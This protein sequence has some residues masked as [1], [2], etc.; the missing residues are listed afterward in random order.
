MK[1]IQNGM[2]GT[3]ESSDIH[4]LIE[5]NEET[6]IEIKLSSP[7]M[8]QFGDQIRQV[9]LDTLERMQVEDVIVT[10]ND[11]GALDYA[12]VARVEAA[13]HRGAGQ[14]VDYEWGGSL[15]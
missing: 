13:A 6:G 3:M 7:V 12:I 1:V 5:P 9:I 11:K 14:Y 8:K 4:I 10:A 2:S 15:A